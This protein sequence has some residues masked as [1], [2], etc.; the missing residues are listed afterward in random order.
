[1]LNY[2]GLNSLFKFKLGNRAYLDTVPYTHLNK[3]FKEI[4]NIKCD[5]NKIAE[6]KQKQIQE[7]DLHKSKFDETI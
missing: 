1:M 6:T 4:T 3:L 5:L 7:N 2:P